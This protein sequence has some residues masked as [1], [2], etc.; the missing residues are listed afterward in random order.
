[1]TAFLATFGLVFLA[2]VGDKSMLLV[3]ALSTRYRP[4]W[5]LLAVTIDSMV[6]MAL[7]VLLGGAADALLPDRA[8]GVGAGLL[9][10]AFGVWAL[11]DEEDEEQPT[12][13]DHRSPVLVIAALT[14]TLFVSEFGD[15]TQIATLSLAGVNPGQQLAVWAGA[16]LGMVSGDA[17][18][19]VVGDRLARRLSSGMVTRIAAI[20]FIATGLVTL[21]FALL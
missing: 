10:I 13:G 11:H 16:T 1:M 21:A 4:W 20:V 2:E 14:V 8:V 18:A 17:L 3:L 7:A 12:D 5:V 9:F 6:V 15:K 19:I